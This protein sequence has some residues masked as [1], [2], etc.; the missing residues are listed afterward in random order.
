MKKFMLIFGLL[1]LFFT[2]TICAK[3]SAPFPNK[4]L[5]VKMY[6][7]VTKGKGKKLGTITIK[8]TRYGVLFTPDLKGLPPGVH[9]FHMHANHSCAQGGKAAGGH[10][11]PKKTDKH[12]GPYNAQGHLGDLPVL[13]IDEDGKATLPVLAPRLKMRDLY[14]HSLIIHAGGDNYSDQP[15]PLGGGGTRIACGLLPTAVGAKNSKK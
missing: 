10:W 1:S 8:P 2:A 12:L 15:L 4:T 11:D 13:L 7:T 9:G 14:G 5:V 6:R 3:K